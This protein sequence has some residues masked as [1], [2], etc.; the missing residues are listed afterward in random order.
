MSQLRQD[1]AGSLVQVFT[2]GY[3]GSSPDAFAL[4]LERNGVLRVVDVR[5]VPRSR[6]TGFSKGALSQMLSRNGLEYVHLRPLGSPRKARQQLRRDRD[7]SSFAAA[8]EA[9]LD[10][11]QNALERLVHL[12]KEMPTAIM[13]LE[14][15]PSRCHRSV[16][17]SRLRRLGFEIVD[18]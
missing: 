13:C 9:H 11:E 18:L 3:E 8:Y 15:E 14:R 10:R 1:L 7:F 6:K 2:I 4:R 12:A 5:E 16:I 17:S